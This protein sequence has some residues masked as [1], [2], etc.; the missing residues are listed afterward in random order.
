MVNALNLKIDELIYYLDLNANNV[1]ETLSPDDAEIIHKYRT[2]DLYGKELVN[3]VIEKESQRCIALNNERAILEDVKRECE[4]IDAEM[5]AKNKK[6]TL[7][8]A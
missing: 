7:F 3:V 2:L 1:E 5:E 6:R 4:K 8:G